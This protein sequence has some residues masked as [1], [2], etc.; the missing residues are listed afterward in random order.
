VVDVSNDA[1]L[2]VRS[3]HGLHRIGAEGDEGCGVS[4]YHY[5]YDVA[6]DQPQVTA[7]WQSWLTRLFPPPA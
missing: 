2:G 6:I 4:A 7:G 5:F 1:F 3:A